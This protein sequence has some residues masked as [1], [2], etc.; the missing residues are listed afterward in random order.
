MIENKSYNFS[1]SF[2]KNIKEKIWY[3]CNYPHLTDNLIPKVRSS[4]HSEHKHYEHGSQ[5]G[6]LRAN[7]FAKINFYYEY[8]K[9]IHKKT[10]YWWKQTIQTKFNKL[11]KK[12]THTIQFHSQTTS[13]TKDTSFWKLQLSF[14]KEAPI[15]SKK[16]FK[17][18][19]KYLY[20]SGKNANIAT[21]NGQR[22]LVRSPTALSTE[23]NIFGKWNR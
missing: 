14:Y 20:M 18:S 11:L 23:R 2:N 13:Y 21:E 3:S 19:G 12:Q 4:Y 1:S 9:F 10:K 17:S 7:Y 15:Y 8:D 6:W 22:T 5:V 16:S